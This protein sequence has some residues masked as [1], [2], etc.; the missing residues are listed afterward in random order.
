[1]LAKEEGSNVVELP[2]DGKKRKAVSRI[3]LEDNPIPAHSPTWLLSC[4][5]CFTVLIIGSSTYR[6]KP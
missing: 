6:R 3:I 5:D 1:M 4:I 2:S